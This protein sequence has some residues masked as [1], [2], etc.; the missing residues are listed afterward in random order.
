MLLQRETELGKELDELIISM[1][2]D[3]VLSKRTD[4][5]VQEEE[6]LIDEEESDAETELAGNDTSDSDEP[7]S[8]KE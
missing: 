3:I 1:R 8:D 5:Q 7:S 6:E 4:E 2:P